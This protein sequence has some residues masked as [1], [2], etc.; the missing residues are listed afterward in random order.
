MILN[1]TSYV[2]KKIRTLCGQLEILTNTKLITD[3]G[4]NFTDIKF[5]DKYGY[6]IIDYKKEIIY[7]LANNLEPVP[8]EIVKDIVLNCN[9][10]EIG[11]KWQ[12]KACNKNVIFIFKKKIDNKKRNV[13][14]DTCKEDK[15]KSSKKTISKELHKM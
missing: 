1:E 4:N 13:Y 2:H 9:W 3:L 5:V 8:F 6:I 14:T 15:S 7:T 12:R 10:L 11:E